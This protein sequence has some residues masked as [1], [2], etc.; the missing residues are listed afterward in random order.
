MLIPGATQPDWGPADVPS[1]RGTTGGLVAKAA[2]VKLGKALRQGF[3]VKVT[4]PSAGRLT[5][6]ASDRG[7]KV[8]SGAK[9]VA[10]GR[11]TVKLRFSRGAR[12]ALDNARSVK[13]KIKVAFKPAGGA[14]Q[15]TT[16][17]V[18]LKR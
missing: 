5:A 1:G 8:A 16:L 14:K 11:A 4:V 7:L 12:A 3:G 18:K 17:A 15:S 6:T 10:A 13:L 2:R 9:Q